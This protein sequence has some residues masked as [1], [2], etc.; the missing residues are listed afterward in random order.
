MQVFVAL[1]PD[2]EAAL[3]RSGTLGAVVPPSVDITATDK[4]QID[5]TTSTSIERD[6]ITGRFCA[7][8]WC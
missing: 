4:Q 7:A 1:V 3:F 8:N 2:D 5:R 6:R